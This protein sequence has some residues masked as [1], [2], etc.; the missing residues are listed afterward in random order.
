MKTRDITILAID[1]S[2]DDQ[3]LIT[4]AFRMNGVTCHISWASSGN[5]AI[6]YLQG[7]GQFSDRSRFPYPTF[8]MTDLKMPNGDGFSVLEH[9]KSKPEWAVIPTLV[10]T[11]SA[12]L[13]DI[14]RSYMLGAGSYIVKRGNFSEMRRVLKV[15]YDYWLE[16]ET[17][18]I[19]A[20]GKRLDTDSKGKL[21]ERFVNQGDN[22][23]AEPD[24]GN[25][26]TKTY[27]GVLP[28][29]GGS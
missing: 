10:F 7:E 13:D 21:G 17:P 26:P 16:C 27:K 9:L 12:D 14:K 18:A 25:Q 11:G 3:D 6:A 29:S 22:E 1:D 4:R 23:V 19:D 15:F 28:A 24:S 2:R 8:I 5:E 20:S